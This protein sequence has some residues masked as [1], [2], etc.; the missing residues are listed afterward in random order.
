MTTPNSFDLPESRPPRVEII[1]LIDVIFFLLATFVLFT[2]S[3][4]KIRAIDVELPKAGTAG[5]ETGTLFLQAAEGG[6]YYW[7]EGSSGRA[8]PISAVELPGRLRD[9]K[10]RATVPRVFIRSDGKARLGSAVV[11]FDEVRKAGIRQVSVET[12]ASAPGS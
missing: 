9:Y 2:L 3:L 11:L 1:P 10:G 5:D 6:V 12:S 4:E 8:E 7:K